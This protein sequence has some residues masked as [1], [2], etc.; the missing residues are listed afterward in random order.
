ME[1]LGMNGG[2]EPRSAH[3]LA[4]LVVDDEPRLRQVLAQVISQDLQSFLR[5]SGRPYGAKPFEFS[6]RLD[7][8]PA[9]RI[10]VA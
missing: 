9:K 5:D 7:V 3:G 4:C 1:R 6:E 2:Q 8:L 10:V